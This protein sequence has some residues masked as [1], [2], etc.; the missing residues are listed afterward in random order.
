MTAVGVRPLAFIGWLSPTQAQT[1]STLA[2][3]L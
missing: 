1:L 2:T 3:G